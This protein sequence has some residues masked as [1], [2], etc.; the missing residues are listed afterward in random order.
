V[1]NIQ[2]RNELHSA[3]QDSSANVKEIVVTLE[4]LIAKQFELS[5]TNLLPKASDITGMAEQTN[6]ELATRLRQS[7]PEPVGKAKFVTLILHLSPFESARR[8]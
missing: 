1:I 4:S 5:R 6:A 8:L 3:A 7:I 2:I